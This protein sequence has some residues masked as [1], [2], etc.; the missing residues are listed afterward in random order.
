VIQGAKLEPLEGGRSNATSMEQG[1]DDEQVDPPRSIHWARCTKSYQRRD[2]EAIWMDVHI[3]KIVLCSLR[4]IR[5]SALTATDT[6]KLKL[7]YS[8]MTRQGPA[9][10]LIPCSRLFHLQNAQVNRSIPKKSRAV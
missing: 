9:S 1:L 7:P 8:P 2:R 10:T 5:A 6:A 4:R 3:S